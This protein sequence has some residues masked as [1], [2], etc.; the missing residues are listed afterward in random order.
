[1]VATLCLGFVLSMVM[2]PAPVILPA[3]LRRQLPYHPLLIAPVVLLHLS[4][5]VRLG[6]QRCPPGARCRVPGGWQAGGV[7]NVAALVLF[8]VLAGWSA[9]TAARGVRRAEVSEGPRCPEGR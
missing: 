3:V 7:G 1:V 9:A 6:A 2:A 4:R 5:A 8:I